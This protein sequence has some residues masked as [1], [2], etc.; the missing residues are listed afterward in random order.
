MQAGSRLMSSVFLAALLI[1][2]GCSKPNSA[3]QDAEIAHGSTIDHKASEAVTM[4]VQ[5]DVDAIPA[6]IQTLLTQVAAAGQTTTDQFN[7]T[8]SGDQV[9]LDWWLWRR[10]LI[11]FK[12]LDP[13]GLPLLGL[14]KAGLALMA[15]PPSWF[16]I[17]GTPDP[18]SICD[19]SGSLTSVTCD[20]KMSY[21]VAPNALGNAVTGGLP[22]FTL[23]VSDSVSNDGKLW[24]ANA[25][26]YG[27]GGS[28][29]A[30]VLTAMLGAPADR[31]AARQKYAVEL[32]AKAEAART[33]GVDVAAP[34][35]QQ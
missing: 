22:P 27:S 9:P 21:A 34:A 23:S 8:I 19:A 13:A 7:I 3:R 14:S 33:G 2:S 6:A 20:I 24:H 35:P 5:S 25:V 29:S 15:K 26:V 11:E 30:V 18:S 16:G 1:G 28:P 12:G 10:G 31:D 32:A 17:V 4:L